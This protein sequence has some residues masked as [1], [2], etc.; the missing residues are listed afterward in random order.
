M[1]IYK[2]HKDQTGET[3]GEKKRDARKNLCLFIDYC[4]SFHVYL[5]KRITG[6]KHS[7]SNSLIIL[8]IV[9]LVVA[10][11]CLADKQKPQITPTPVR[12]FKMVEDKE[13]N[14]IEHCLIKGN[15]NSKGERIYHCP[16]WR[17]YSKTIIEEDKGEMWFCTEV[18]AINSGW[19]APKYPTGPCW[20]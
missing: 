11:P 4:C 14:L 3:C 6:K 2:Y 5:I 12:V 7:D 15:I 20:F 16:G 19:R 9:I 10:T 1:N 18:E 13:G 8:F 17:D